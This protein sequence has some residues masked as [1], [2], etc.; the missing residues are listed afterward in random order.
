MAMRTALP[1][2]SALRPRSRTARLAVSA[3]TFV[4]PEP[5]PFSVRPEKALE[6]AQC[7]AGFLF[8][9][10]SGALVAGYTPSAEEVGAEAP[11]SYAGSLRAA[12]R[13]LRESSTLVATWKRPAQPLILYEFQVSLRAA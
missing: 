3:K 4:P 11:T 6:T 12:G 5:K 9:G 1:R 13:G 2:T 7:A 10:T 8:R